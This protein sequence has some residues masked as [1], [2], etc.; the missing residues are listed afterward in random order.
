MNIF[1]LERGRDGG[2]RLLGGI[3]IFGS[4]ALRWC[5]RRRIICHAEE[6]G[7]YEDDRWR[8]VGGAC[9]S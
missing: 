7:C 6:I 4:Y 9:R 5:S 1:L 2:S 8:I 3:S